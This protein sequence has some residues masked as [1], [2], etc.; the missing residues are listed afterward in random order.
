MDIKPKKFILQPANLMIKS[1][2]LGKKKANESF[3]DS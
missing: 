1:Q 2:F 3:N